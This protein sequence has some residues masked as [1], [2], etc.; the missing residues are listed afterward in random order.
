MSYFSWS[1]LHCWSPQRNSPAVC[2]Y[3]LVGYRWLQQ[4]CSSLSPETLAEPWALQCHSKEV[5]SVVASCA[6]GQVISSFSLICFCFLRGENEVNKSPPSGAQGRISAEFNVLNMVVPP[7]S[8]KYVLYKYYMGVTSGLWKL[9]QGFILKKKK[10]SFTQSPS[11][12]LLRH[13]HINLPQGCVSMREALSW[14]KI[15]L[16]VSFLLSPFSFTQHIILHYTDTLSD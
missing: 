4:H 16:S 11:K 9:L 2:A 6:S 10:K 14:H 13:A 7:A 3:G 8:H 12:H 1:T 5:G 15:K